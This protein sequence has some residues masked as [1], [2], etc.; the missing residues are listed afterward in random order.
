MRPT[1]KRPCVQHGPHRPLRRQA[2]LPHA[3]EDDKLHRVPTHGA[4]VHTHSTRSALPRTAEGLGP[5]VTAA[6]M[7][8]LLR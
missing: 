3:D 2:P 6:V 1:S 8:H 4:G 7:G 5:S